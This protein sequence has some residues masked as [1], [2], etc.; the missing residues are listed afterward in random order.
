[1]AIRI[2]SW[3]ADPNL[4]LGASFFAQSCEAFTIKLAKIMTV[5]NMLKYLLIRGD[6]NEVTSYLLVVDR[7][8]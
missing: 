7:F 1:M 3:G 8:K 4:L 5:M 6:V 2:R